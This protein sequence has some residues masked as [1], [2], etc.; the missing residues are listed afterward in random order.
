MLMTDSE[1]IV[2]ATRIRDKIRENFAIVHLSENLINTIKI[3]R[4]TLGFEIEIPAEM[5]DIQKYMQQGVIVYTGEGSYAQQVNI[6]GGFSKKHK[7]YIEDA[8]REGIEIW[9]KE[10]SLK[11]ERISWI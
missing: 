5:Y 2:L 9:L 1:L 7:N 11:A 10:M 3:N 4:T 6:T 8:I